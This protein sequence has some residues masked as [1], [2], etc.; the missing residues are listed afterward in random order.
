MMK[1]VVICDDQ[2]HVVTPLRIKFT[3]AGY[4]AVIAHDGQEAWQEIQECI[5]DLLVTDLCMPEMDGYELVKRLRSNPATKHIP[6]VLLT[7]VSLDTMRREVIE[8]LDITEVIPKPY[9]AKA[10]LRAAERVIAAVSM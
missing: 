8:E 9:S 4:D 2:L 6:V 10:V 5:P 1:R 3:K 7:G